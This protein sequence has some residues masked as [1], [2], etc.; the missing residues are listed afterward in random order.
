MSA[1]EALS[2][3]EEVGHNS[4]RGDNVDDSFVMHV[5]LAMSDCFC[6]FFVCAVIIHQLSIALNFSESCKRASCT[7]H[8]NVICFYKFHK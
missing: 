1:A 7:L 2:E 6:Q 5:F 8:G 3:E 4:M